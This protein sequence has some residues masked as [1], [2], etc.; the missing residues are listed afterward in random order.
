R[1]LLVPDLPQGPD[2]VRAVP[3][4]RHRFAY[5]LTVDA[6]GEGHARGTPPPERVCRSLQPPADAPR[7]R[8]GRAHRP[9]LP[10]A[11]LRPGAAHAARRPPPGAVANRPRGAR[12][13]R[14][15]GGPSGAPRRTGPARCRASDR[16]R[17]TG[18]APTCASA[19][20]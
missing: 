13:A 1:L 14:G 7:G 10:H 15:G 19:R 16:P 9:G 3:D 8:G 18:S 2:L 5:T 4:G 20:P 12:P 11:P 6:R 17:G